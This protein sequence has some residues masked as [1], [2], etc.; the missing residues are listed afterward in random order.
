MFTSKIANEIVKETSLRLSRNVNIMNT[1][2]IIIATMDQTR[3]GTVHKGAVEVLSTQKTLIIQQD[4]K[5]EG[6]Q[7]GINLPVIFMNQIIGVIGIT[8]NPKELGNIGELVKMT[9]ELMIRQ[10]F[11]DSQLEWKQRTKET[12]I[13]QLLKK[14]PSLSILNQHLG[15]LS[16]KLSPPFTSIVI[17][18]TERSIPN[19]QLIEMIEEKIGK[20]NGIVGFITV[21]RLFIMLTGILESEINQKINSIYELF[22]ELNT[23]FR[24]SY[25]LSFDRL[26]QSSQAYNECE[27]SL[28][29]SE[30]ETELASF[31][32]IEAKSLLYKVDQTVAERFSK[33]VL[34]KLDV[35]QVKTLEAFFYNSLNI[36][37]TADDLYLHRNTLIYRINKI[38]EETGYNPKNFNE[39]SILQVAVWIYRKTEKNMS[40]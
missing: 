5:W 34:K 36:Q 33:R 1:D 12:I 37:R 11:M 24:M 38:I 14:E 21:N 4:Q 20:N 35:N 26:S 25:S 10:E 7:P 17:Q 13:D 9:A 40:L 28:D 3:I 15:L 39:A 2:G 8:G 6:A 22:K 16:L 19:R 31:E 32:Q 23:K 30:P 29:I 18:M 27:I